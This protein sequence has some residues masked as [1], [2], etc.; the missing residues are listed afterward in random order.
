MDNEDEDFLEKFNR[1][2]NSAGR[3]S[4]TKL[5]RMLWK[6]EITWGEIVDHTLSATGGHRTG[7]YEQGCGS[8]ALLLAGT[9]R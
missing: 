1:Q 9:D 3:L 7:W 8:S 4:D 5:E 6:L 2:E